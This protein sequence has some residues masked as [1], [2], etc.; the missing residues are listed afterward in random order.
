MHY[1]YT[2]SLVLNR[3]GLHTTHYHNYI[4][5]GIKSVTVT[6]SIN[7]TVN[8]ISENNIQKLIFFKEEGN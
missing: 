4:I 5:C 2:K 3:L 1:R 8:I 6:S 7:Y